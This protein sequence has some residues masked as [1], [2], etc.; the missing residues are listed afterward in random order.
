MHKKVTKGR[1]RLSGALEGAFVS[2]I[3][4]AN[5][6]LSEDTPKGVP[7]GRYKDAQ[8]GG[9]RLKLRVHLR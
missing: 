7:S 9:F 1:I 2:A 3:E 8:E 6:G 5:E 4:N